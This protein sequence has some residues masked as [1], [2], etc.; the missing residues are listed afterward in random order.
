LDF[1]RAS[2]QLI[3]L[4]FRRQP[5]VQFMSG[6]ETPSLRPYVRGLCDEYVALFV[7]LL[8]RSTEFQGVEVMLF[9]V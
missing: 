9:S 7:R 6:F 5:V 1:S 4:L 8:L 2:Q 3:K